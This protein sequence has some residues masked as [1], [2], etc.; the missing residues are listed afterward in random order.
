MDSS[1]TQNPNR[2]YQFI[3]I[4]YNQE[5][6][7]LEH[8]QSI[9]Y[10][11]E[12]YGKNKKIILS[13]FDDC[14]SDSNAKVIRTFLDQNTHLFHSAKLIVND[15]NL[16]IKKNYL[17]SLNSIVTNRFKILAGD[18]LYS[19]SRNIFEFMDYCSD[20][21]VVFSPVYISGNYLFSQLLY[22]GKI[23][24]LSKFPSLLKKLIINDINFFYAAGSFISRNILQSKDYLNALLNAEVDYED[25]PS[26]QFLFV[27]NLYNF[28]VYKSPVVDYRV[29]NNYKLN[30]FYSKSE[31]LVSVFSRL[32]RAVI[33]RFNFKFGWILLVS[34]LYGFVYAIIYRIKSLIYTD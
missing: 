34:E 11:I 12:T 4:T 20:L 29:G 22:T 15:T 21:D 31:L 9:K 8:L 23:L 27:E 6:L 24:F 30:N 32:A 2:V 3:T 19:N 7:I 14:S 28:K 13:V 17:K 16:G 10:Q 18:D 25:S 1:L 5:L 33:L 26:W